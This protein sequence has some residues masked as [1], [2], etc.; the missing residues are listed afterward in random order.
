MSDF[1]PADLLTVQ[2]QSRGE[3]I[4]YENVIEVPSKVRG[5]YYIGNGDRKLIDFWCVYPDGTINHKK[6]AKNE[7]IFFFD[8][9]TPGVYQFI[10][11]NK[12]VSSNSRVGNRRT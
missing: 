9:Y 8:A 12:R 5:A 1:E 4:F 10:F 7:G 6:E 11:S 3:E 2:I